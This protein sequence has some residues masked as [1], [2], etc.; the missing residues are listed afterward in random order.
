[1]T[2]QLEWANGSK[3]PAATDQLQNSR[4][5]F[6]RVVELVAF[7]VAFAIWFCFLEYPVVYIT[8][9]ADWSFYGSL[10]TMFFPNANPFYFHLGAYETFGSSGPHQL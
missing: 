4:F 1:M 5:G 10:A 2:L 6:K 8:G 9:G 7:L 3:D